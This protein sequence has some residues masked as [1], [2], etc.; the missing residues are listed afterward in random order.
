MWKT[1]EVFFNQWIG[2]WSSL[3]NRRS[4]HF[5]SWNR[6]VPGT[7]ETRSVQV[8]YREYVFSVEFAA[9]DY[10]SPEKCQYA[11]KLEG[12]DRDWRYGGARRAAFYTNLDGGHYLF[13]VR[14]SNSDGV[15]SSHEANLAIDVFP[16]PWKRTWF[17]VLAAMLVLGALAWAYHARVAQLRRARVAQETFSRRLIESQEAERKRI[18]AELHDSLGQNLVVIKN[19]ALLGLKD[20]AGSQKRFDEISSTASLALEEVRQIAHD[21]RPYQLDRLGLTKALNSLLN[22]ANDSSAVAF[23]AEIDLVDDVLSRKEDQ[24]NLYRV[25]QESVTNILK[26]SAAT[27]ARLTVTRGAESVI[28]RME[29]NGRGFDVEAPDRARDGFGV[30]GMAERARILGARY[31]IRSTPG[32][33]TTILLDIPLRKE[34]A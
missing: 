17:I 34:Q 25:V 24:I 18:A 12:F 3:L 16:P 20:G 4:W 27:E 10:T 28:V 7:S 30:S 6:Q 32:K 1:S 11:Y 14:G 9:L 15:W 29:D 33:G 5:G 2:L 26:H 23:T 21:L 13:R 19:S 31:A 22:Q 8:S